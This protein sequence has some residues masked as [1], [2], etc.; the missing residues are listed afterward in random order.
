M[1]RN[2][3][4]T[5]IMAKSGA[6]RSFLFPIMS[7]Y[8]PIVIG[9]GLVGSAIAYGLARGGL[10][11]ALLDEGDVAFRASRGNF[12]LVWVQSKGIGVPEYQ[13]W[14]RLSSELWDDF[15][16]ELGKETGIDC[17]HEHRGGVTICLTEQ[18]FAQRMPMMERLRLDSGEP[19]F[20]DPIV[21][22]RE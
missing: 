19:R 20:E 12:G 17:A 21:G 1:S 13:R 8:D 5:A 7:R 4:A 18:D 3:A 2:T 22:Q 14:S 15:A 6:L 11:A 9:G 16:V 10:K